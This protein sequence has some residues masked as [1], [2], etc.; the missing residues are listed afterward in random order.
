VDKVVLLEVGQ[1]REALGADVALEGPLA[2]VRPQVHLEVGE[3]AKSLVADVALVVHLSVLFL[4]RVGQRPVSPGGGRVG[5]HGA[6]AGRQ[7]RV[8]R[9]ALRVVHAGR[10]RLQVQRRQQSAAG[11][12]RKGR[13]RLHVRRVL[14]QV[15]RRV[16]RG[17]VDLRVVGVEAGRRVVV[18]AKE[19]RAVQ[20]VRRR[21]RRRRLRRAHLLRVVVEVVVGRRRRRGWRHAHHRRRRRLLVRARVGTGRQRVV[22]VRFF[23]RVGHLGGA[24]GTTLAR[25]HGRVQRASRAGAAVADVQAP[26]QDVLE[27]ARAGGTLAGGV[28]LVVGFVG[29]EGHRTGRLDRVGGGAGG[30][31]SGALGAHSGGLGARLLLAVHHRDDGGGRLGGHV[32]LALVVVRLGDLD[33]DFAELVFGRVRGLVAQELGAARLGRR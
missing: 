13:D 24:R 20:L 10:R 16:G 28:L 5:T 7:R 14:H 22:A 12:R 21:R 6:A 18:H 4:Q 17:R 30:G 23:V 9:R 26:H 31:R 8:R 11:R 29:F 27:D 2:R 15:G 25:R 1:L 32:R 19:G 3:L 33:F